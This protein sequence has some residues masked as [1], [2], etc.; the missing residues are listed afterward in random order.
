MKRPEVELS[1][2]IQCGV[3]IEVCPEVFVMNEAGF[4]QVEDLDCYPEEKVAEAI[5][6]CPADCI[7]WSLN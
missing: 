3:C 2:C 1:D 5:K 7:K 6:N 4:I